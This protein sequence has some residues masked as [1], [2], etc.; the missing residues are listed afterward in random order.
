MKTD[1]DLSLLITTSGVDRLSPLTAELPLPLLPLA[2]RPLLGHMLEAFARQGCRQALV[3]L[4]DPAGQI[5]QRFGDGRRWGFELSYYPQ[6]TALGNAGVLKRCEQ[7]LHATT[8]VVPTDALFELN[9]AQ[10]LAIHRQHGGTLTVILH[11]ALLDD[12]PGLSLNADGTIADN[13]DVGRR[14]AV[15]GAYIADQRLLAQLPLGERCDLLADLIPALREANLTV[16]GYVAEGYWNP[17]RTAADYLAA[18]TH[19]LE[20]KASCC[21]GPE[22]RE[23]APGIWIGRGSL[24]HPE[25][26]LAPPIQIG[27][28]CQIG[29]DVELGPHVVIG[30]NVVVDDE[31]TVRESAVLDNTYVGQFVSIE[32]RIVNRDLIVDAVSGACTTIVDPFLL[33]PIRPLQFGR[34][35]RWLHWS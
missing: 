19:L 26:R 17:L 24:I 12:R 32:R 33:A 1:S 10:A 30:S 7:A 18:Q 27:A 16:H 21:I 11:D 20:H 9:L 34:L 4:V 5:E 23:V 28:N 8:L 15:T 22:G 29:R 31:A 25:A 6:S 14:A 13:G 2:N 35:S 3:S